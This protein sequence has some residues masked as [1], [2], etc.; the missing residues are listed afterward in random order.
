MGSYQQN[1][2]TTQ[3]NNMVE[4]SL[5]AKEDLSRLLRKYVI[6]STLEVSKMTLSMDHEIGWQGV[7]A[8]V[9]TRGTFSSVYEVVL[10]AI[11][12]V[13][14]MLGLPERII[15]S[16]DGWDRDYEEQL[17]DAREMIM[18]VR[19]EW[20]ML[21][22]EH[23][24]RIE[25]EAAEKAEWIRLEEM[26]RKEDVAEEAARVRWEKMCREEED[27]RVAESIQVTGEEIYTG[28]VTAVVSVA[29][30][31]ADDDAQDDTARDI[32]DIGQHVSSDK[33]KENVKVDEILSVFCRTVHREVRS[34]I[35]W[36]GPWRVRTSAEGNINKNERGK[37]YQ[38]AVK[39]QSMS[40]TCGLV[41]IRSMLLWIGPW[42]VRI[43]LT[44]IIVLVAIPRYLQ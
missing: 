34:M 14:I 23:K 33:E 10:D 19:R 17:A 2:R 21:L 12:Q 38:R 27:E 5:E 36:I 20:D 32:H 25:D 31:G 42:R 1:T 18:I 44:A 22:W 37:K 35:L 40:V 9:V 30:Q 4:I 29:C 6:I 16:K 26:C 24:C 39:W 13:Y 8:C 11:F 43:C 15:F 7:E 3:N 28:S 41:G